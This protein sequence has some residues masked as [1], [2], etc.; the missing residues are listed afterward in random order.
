MDPFGF[1]SLLTSIAEYR[2]VRNILNRVIESLLNEN[3]PSKRHPARSDDR[4]PRLL[5]FS[6][7][8]S[9]KRQTLSVG[10][11]DLVQFTLAVDRDIDEFQQELSPSHPAILR[12]LKT[13]ATAAL[14]RDKP[15]V[16]CDKSPA[17]ASILRCWLGWDARLS[18]RPKDNAPAMQTNDSEY[19]YSGGSKVLQPEC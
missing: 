3:P 8:R 5:R 18:M 15:V 9:Q 6:L 1:C 4:N 19:G 11:N 10:T 7:I 14:E 17:Y 16:V 2:A 12:L 13:I